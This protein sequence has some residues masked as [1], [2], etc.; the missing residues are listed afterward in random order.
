MLT[1]DLDGQKRVDRVEIAW[2]QPATA[3]DIE[4]ASGGGW[5]PFF[6]TSGNALT[7]TVALGPSTSGSSLRLRMTAPH[8]AFGSTGHV[9]Y[10]IRSVRVYGSGLRSVNLDL[11]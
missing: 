9:G 6:S 3:F 4:F 5:V 10:G 1:L 11:Y 8:A 2:E 7:Q